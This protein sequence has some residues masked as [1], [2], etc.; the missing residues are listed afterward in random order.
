MG[1]EK[2]VQFGREGRC[3]SGLDL[4]FAMSVR[5]MREDIQ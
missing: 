3:S 1:D 2:T 4:T 5:H